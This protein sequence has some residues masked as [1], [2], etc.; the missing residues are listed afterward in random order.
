M[1]S[2]SDCYSVPLPIQPGS[3]NLRRHLVVTCNQGSRSPQQHSQ[4]RVSDQIY[5]TLDDHQDLEL[6]DQVESGSASE[7]EGSDEVEDVDVISLASDIE[8]PDHGEVQSSD[9]YGSLNDKLAAYDSGDQYEGHEV[10][11]EDVLDMWLRPSTTTIPSETML[12]TD[13]V[14][15]ESSVERQSWVRSRAEKTSRAA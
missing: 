11:D 9:M 12:R 2:R 13:A 7:V 4:P 15:P 14:R 6:E 1:S 3:D 10:D 5:L 8:I